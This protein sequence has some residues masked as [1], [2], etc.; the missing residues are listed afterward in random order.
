MMLQSLIRLTVWFVLGAQLTLEVQAV[1]NDNTDNAL[2]PYWNVHAGP[3]S[4]GGCDVYED[5][6]KTA[7]EEVCLFARQALLDV[8]FIST[9]YNNGNGPTNAN[10]RPRWNRVWNTFIALFGSPWDDQG[11]MKQPISD[12]AIFLTESFYSGVITRCSS[13]AGPGL[14]SPTLY[15]SDQHFRFVRNG[16]PDPE[17]ASQKIE[18]THPQCAARGGIWYSSQ[19]PAGYHYID[20]LP[21]ANPGDPPECSAD[22]MAYTDM[23]APPP[24]LVS[25]CPGGLDDAVASI[26]AV[27]NKIKGEKAIKGT[28]TMLILA[29]KITTLYD[30]GGKKKTDIPT[31]WLHELAHLIANRNDEQT[32]TKDGKLKTH[33]ET[34]W[35]DAEGK[36]VSQNVATKT[37]TWE[38]AVR[39]AQYNQRK[40][41]KSPENLALFGKAMFLSE[42]DWHKGYAQPPPP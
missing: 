22:T 37:Y 2:R 32:Y 8:R 31:A 14:E 38:A 6:L 36:H 7:W 42:W 41:G 13:R 1:P 34:K 40:A 27:R 23:T 3:V 18:D 17:D 12:N 20:S 35:S 39:L 26:H 19:Y 15:C 28:T 30:A 9:N 5:R 25:F 21:P 4:Q 24:K 11:N 29:G 10:N 16:E 33:K